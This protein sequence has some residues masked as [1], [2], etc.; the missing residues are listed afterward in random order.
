MSGKIRCQT[1]F[2]DSSSYAGFVSTGKDGK[3]FLFDVGTGITH[4]L[5]E[6]ET[7]ECRLA[8]AAGVVKGLS[9]RVKDDCGA[10]L[11]PE[12]VEAL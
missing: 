10:P 6:S 2:R 11:E 8:H 1:P 9:E 4:W 5:N 7:E 3:P 12:S